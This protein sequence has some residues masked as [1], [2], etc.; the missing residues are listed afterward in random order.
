MVGA[1]ERAGY[2]KNLHGW[3]KEKARYA[4]AKEEAQNVTHMKN[5][6]YTRLLTNWSTCT[7]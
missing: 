1:Y 5:D 3:E 6:Q 7:S 4:A 2:E